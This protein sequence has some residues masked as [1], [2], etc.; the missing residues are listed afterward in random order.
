MQLF[1]SFRRLAVAIY[2]LAAIVTVH[3]YID[4]V[5]QVCE[6]SAGGYDLA[7]YFLGDNTFFDV[8]VPL[9]TYTVMKYGGGVQSY[10]YR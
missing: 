5:L 2:R 4:L 8:R 10:N 7:A 1:F 3:G 6:I 9:F